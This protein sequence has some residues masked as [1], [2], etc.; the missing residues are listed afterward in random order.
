MFPSDYPKLQTVYCYF[1]IWSQ[2]DKNGISIIDKVLQKMVKQIHNDDLWL[3]KTTLRIVDTQS[4]KNT[5]TA[6]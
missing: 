3:N 6:E 5:D 2:K 1:S 4:A